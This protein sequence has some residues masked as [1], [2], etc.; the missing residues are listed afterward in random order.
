MAYVA[1]NPAFIGRVKDR[2]HTMQEAEVKTLGEMPM[3]QI[4]D[5]SDFF[6]DN[7]WGEHKH[8]HSLMPGDYKNNAHEWRVIIEIPNAAEGVQ[9]F[10]VAINTRHMTDAYP[11]NHSW[12]SYKKVNADVEKYPEVAPLVAYLTSK[13]E[14]LSRWAN[15]VDKVVGF[16]KECKSLNEAVKLWPDL[17]VYIDDSDIQRLEVKVTKGEK[18]SKAAEALASLDTD[19]LMGAAVIARLSGAEV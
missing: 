19:E 9:A 13:A 18:S 8:L 12:Y 5:K 11:P 15:V 1:I 17:K 7:V 3:P 14:I 10:E 16:L 2:I 4:T 6:L